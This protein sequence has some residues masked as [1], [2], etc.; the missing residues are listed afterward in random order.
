M[1]GIIYLIGG[2]EPFTGKSFY[3][4]SVG[5]AAKNATTTNTDDLENAMSESTSFLQHGEGDGTMAD[6]EWREVA[7]IL[8]K[9]LTKALDMLEVEHPSHLPSAFCGVCNF[10]HKSGR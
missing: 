8:D 4:A 6:A 5:V 1:H 10:L 7:Q 3:S 9:E 2:T